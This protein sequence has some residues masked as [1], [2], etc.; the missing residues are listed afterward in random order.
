MTHKERWLRLTLAIVLAWTTV[1]AP[2]LSANEPDDRVIEALARSLEWLERH[3]VDPDVA[4]LGNVGFDT[5]SWWLFSVWHPDA[6]VRERA[7]TEVDHRLRALKSPREWNAVALSYWVVL[8]RIGQL[9]DVEIR[10]DLPIPSGDQL[11]QMLST[12]SS[13]TAWWIHQ[14]LGHLGLPANPDD[15]TTLIGAVPD[16]PSEYA[17]T[18]MDTYRVFHEIVPATNLG[19]ASFEVTAVQSDFIHGALPGWVD[20]SRAAGDTDAVAEAL[21]VAALVGGRNT[22]TYDAALT[23]L[24]SR[25][26]ANGTYIIANP[27]PGADDYRHVVLVGSWALLA[28]LDGFEPRV[29]VGASGIMGERR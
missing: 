19:M 23:W 16:N 21:V 6:E 29:T 11:H 22:T 20:V 27:R 7:G 25:Q 24:L 12:G 10:T 8:L 17:A 1:S 5:W 13:T 4:S 9:R 3:P 15:S 2:Q 26:K 18:V 28:S 14:L